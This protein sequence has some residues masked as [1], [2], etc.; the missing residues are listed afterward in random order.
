VHFCFTLVPK[1]WVIFW[2]WSFSSLF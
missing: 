2:F 1:L